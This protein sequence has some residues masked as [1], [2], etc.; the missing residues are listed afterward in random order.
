MNK[1]VLAN[2]AGM[3][4]QLDVTVKQVTLN[5]TGMDK[6]NSVSSQ[7]V[8]EMSSFSM[9]TRSMSSLPM[10]NSLVKKSTV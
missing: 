7:T 4:S 1:N 8:L 10:I 6:I 3:I 5:V 9:N 2:V